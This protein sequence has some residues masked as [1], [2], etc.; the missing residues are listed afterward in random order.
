MQVKLPDRKGLIARDRNENISLNL[1]RE[2]NEIGGCE[3]N[4]SIG[5][6]PAAAQRIACRAPSEKKLTKVLGILEEE[7]G[8]VGSEWKER[9]SKE[10]TLRRFE[11]FR[12]RGGEAS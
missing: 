6:R 7:T 1:G 8:L 3:G 10:V 5:G 12:L 11:V 2:K 4:K 9:I